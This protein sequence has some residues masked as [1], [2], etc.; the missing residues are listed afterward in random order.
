MISTKQIFIVYHPGMF[1]TMLASL[2][3]DPNNALVGKKGNSH[4]SAGNWILRNFHDVNHAEYLLS[5][6]EEARVDFFQ[7]LKYVHDRKCIHRLAS[8]QFLK[9]PF[10]KYF[11]SFTVVAL[12]PEHDSTHESWASRHVHT[13]SPSGDKMPEKLQ[14][15]KKDLEHVHEGKY[16]IKF[17]PINFFDFDCTQKLL[18]DICV[19]SKSD[20]IK[21]PYKNW[22]K[23]MSKNKLFFDFASKY[24]I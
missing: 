7:P 8:Y 4:N 1:G 9:I 3:N 23:H 22:S 15:L 20:R 12:V 13:T 16:H 19:H 18:T 5:I 14:Y 21:I 2:L 24:T 17:D 10:E 11:K 6:D